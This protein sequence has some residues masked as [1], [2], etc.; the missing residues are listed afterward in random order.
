MNNALT[1]PYLGI[2]NMPDLSVLFRLTFVLRWDLIKAKAV[3]LYDPLIHRFCIYKCRCPAQRDVWNEMVQNW[4]QNGG[5]EVKMDDINTLDI[6]PETEQVVLG[7]RHRVVDRWVME[8]RA[9]APAP[10]TDYLHWTH[11]RGFVTWIYRMPRG[12][13][14]A[15]EEDG[16]LQQSV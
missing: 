7:N 3:L 14:M 10:S 6:G 15:R 12:A 5:K 11:Y 8:G 9:P 13:L 16:G 4:K 2:P 1:T